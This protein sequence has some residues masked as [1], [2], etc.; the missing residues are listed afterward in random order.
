MDEEETEGA[1]AEQEA[2]AVAAK[3]KREEAVS[4]AKAEETADEATEKV[5]AGPSTEGGEVFAVNYIL[6]DEGFHNNEA[7][8]WVLR[9]LQD[10][11]SFGLS[12]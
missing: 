3:A 12:P 7:V 4:A 5:N 1:K 8:E 2:A 6:T 9:R 10:Q 11:V